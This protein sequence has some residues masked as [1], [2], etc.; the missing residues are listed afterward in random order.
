MSIEKINHI[1]EQIEESIRNFD[2]P[3]TM[4]MLITFVEKMDQIMQRDRKAWPENRIKRFNGLVKYLLLSIENGDL[5]FAQ[6]VLKN[7]LLP[8]I[9]QNPLELLMPDEI[10]IKIEDKNTS[11]IRKQY[12]SY[13]YPNL[14]KGIIPDNA[15]QIKRNRYKISAL[16]NLD[17][18]RHIAFDKF[19]DDSELKVLIAGCGTGEDAIISALTFLKASYTFIDISKESL[20]IAKGYIKELGLENVKVLEEDIMTMELNEKYDIIISSGVIHHLSNPS[21]GI[22]NLKNHLKE[23]GVLAGM[24]YG[25]YGRLEITVFQEVLKILQEGNPDFNEGIDLVKKI[26]SETK[27]DSRVSNIAWKEDLFKGEQHIV[28]L[29]L[30]VNEVTYTTE[31]LKE[32]IEN[33]GMKILQFVEKSTLNPKNYTNDQKILEKIKDLDYFRRCKLAELLNGRLTKLHF[34][35]IKNQKSEIN[36]EFELSKVKKMKI[37]KSP[38]LTLKTVEEFGEKRHYLNLFSAGLYESE[39][40]DYKDIEVDEAVIKLLDSC[41]GQKDLQYIIENFGNSINKERTLE[42]LEYAYNNNIIFLHCD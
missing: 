34:F 23:N 42:F 18:I 24:V 5:E 10:L 17:Y 15:K 11:E 35:A 22:S 37:H 28:D 8:Y 36:I 14:W 12:T 6:M 27:K 2:K 20:N 39:L 33:G 4:E 3:K 30:N 7:N 13:A 31:T 25:K 19:I 38:Y 41:D 29:L 26:L 40:G 21:E 32:M 9:N 1:A 16:Y